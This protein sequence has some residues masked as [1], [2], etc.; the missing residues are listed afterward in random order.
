MLVVADSSALVAL[1]VCDALPLLDRLFR[2]VVVPPT[3]F[4]EC[5]VSGK[6]AAQV[7]NEYL[8]DKVAEVDL[9]AYAIAAVELGRGEL[10]AMALCKRLEADR[11]LVD[12]RRARGIAR[13]NG[14]TVIGS[15]GV[16]LAAKDQGLVLA[17]RP[18]LETIRSAGIRLGEPVI[19]EALRLAGESP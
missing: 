7:L 15:V 18:L 6:P 14:I 4:Q 12:D 8:R 3:V 11:L 1:A 16:L 17:I 19:K 10:E 9:A 2:E 5:T 13:V